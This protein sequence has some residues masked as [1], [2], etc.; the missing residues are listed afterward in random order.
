MQQA[1]RTRVASFST[2]QSLL[3]HHIP[4]LTAAAAAAAPRRYQDETS[5]WTL[6]YPPLFAWFEWALSQAA[7]WADPA[8]LVSSLTLGCV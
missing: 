2:L 5:Q 8:M 3:L 7:R 6:D 1:E 4:H